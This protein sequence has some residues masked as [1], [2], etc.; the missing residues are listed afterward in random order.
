[1]KT[2]L[3]FTLCNLPFVL[4]AQTNFNMNIRYYT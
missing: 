4:L 1:M 2:L 3:L